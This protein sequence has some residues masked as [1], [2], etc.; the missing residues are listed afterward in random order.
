MLS[1][2]IGLLNFIE[3][4]RSKK[5]ATR[6]KKSYVIVQDTFK[7]YMDLVDI[8]RADLISL[9]R[10]GE[11]NPMIIPKGQV[12][13]EYVVECDEDEIDELMDI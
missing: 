8:M 11:F 4:S 13:T 1:T 9:K 12:K 7:K 2:E 6:D 5:K 10:F 3:T